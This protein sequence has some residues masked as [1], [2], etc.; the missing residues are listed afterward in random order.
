MAGTSTRD[1]KQGWLQRV[2]ALAFCIAACA[3]YAWFAVTAYRAHRLADST[4]QSSIAKA[5]AL[6]PMN[7]ASHDLLCRSMIFASQDPE[8]AVDACRKASELN[9][10]DSSI[11][12]DLAQA[13]YSA[14]DKHLTDAAIHK[15]LAVDPTTPDTVWNVANFFLVEGNIAEALKQYAIVLR[16]DPSLADPTLNICWQSLHDVGRIQGM[17]PP[18]PE[19]YLA[20]IKLLLSTGEVSAAHQ[21]WS[22]L[23]GLNTGMDYHQALFYIDSLIQGHDVSQAWEAWKQLS[24]RSKDL[25][26]YSQQGNLVMDGSFSQEVLD[27]GF[28]WRYVSMPDI[29]VTLDKA[30]SHSGGRSVRLAYRGSNGDAGISQYIAAQP[31]MR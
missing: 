6:A 5:V 1:S 11:W 28:D 31:G 3:V 25:L 8:R 12:M 18:N 20:F 27:S 14:G 9:P 17:L 23:I 16:E 2:L 26:A 21:V 22:A 10:Y 4:D 30:E 29:T 19:V 7:A 13:Y 15:A 24:S